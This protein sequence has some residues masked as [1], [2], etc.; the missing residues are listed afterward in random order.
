MIAEWKSAVISPLPEVIQEPKSLSETQGSVPVEAQ[1]SH[2]T[3][4]VSSQGSAV[5][6][7]PIAVPADVPRNERPKRDTKK[8]V[9]FD[10]EFSQL[11]SNKPKSTVKKK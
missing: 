2:R 6:P 11:G 10:E 5:S 7:V 4:I 1:M 9:R 3:P 8:A